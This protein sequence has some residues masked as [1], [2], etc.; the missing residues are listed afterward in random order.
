M[1]ATPP[2]EDVEQAAQSPD[3]P[4]AQMN[5]DPQSLGLAYELDVKGTYLRLLFIVVIPPKFRVTLTSFSRARPL[6]SDS[7]W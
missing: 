7:K 3:D 2:K 5:H 6:A 1:S 4:D